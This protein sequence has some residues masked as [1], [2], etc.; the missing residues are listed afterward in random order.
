MLDLDKE[1]V[2]CF[3]RHWVENEITDYLEVLNFTPKAVALWASSYDGRPILYRTF[4]GE[5][6]LR[7]TTWPDGSW[8][9]DTP[10]GDFDANPGGF[11]K[12]R[13]LDETGDDAVSNPGRIKAHHQPAKIMTILTE[14]LR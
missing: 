7:L 6:L 3:L 4:N 12:M 14:A 9:I 11:A 8:V 10:N 2:L 1:N 5:P 13:W